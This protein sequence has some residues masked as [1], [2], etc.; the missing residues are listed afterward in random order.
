MEGGSL[1]V[2]FQMSIRRKGARSPVLLV[3]TELGF[4]S[5]IICTT[6]RP[7]AESLVLLIKDI[8]CEKTVTIGPGSS[9][10]K[11]VERMLD[12]NVSSLLVVDGSNRMVGIIDES[13]LLAATFDGQIRHD[14]V[15]LHMERK[16]ASVRPSDSIETAIERSIL[17]RIRHL[18]VIEAGR[19]VG[20]VTRRDLLRAVFGQKR[21]AGVSILS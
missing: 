9:V 10:Q 12:E 1:D 16:F 7:S 2:A 14:P 11:S 6:N 17:H 13:A 21:P 15:S 8:M 5:S 18:P 4:S 20:L 3:R 19:L